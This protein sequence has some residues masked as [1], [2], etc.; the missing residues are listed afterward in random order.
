MLDTGC[1]WLLTEHVDDRRGYSTTRTIPDRGSRA[2]RGAHRSGVDQPP[3]AYG[4]TATR[5][6]YHVG[7][8][9]VAVRTYALNWTIERTC[10]VPR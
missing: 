1:R 9:G 10:L 4:G 5:F 2:P 6:D 7:Y 3:V 8:A